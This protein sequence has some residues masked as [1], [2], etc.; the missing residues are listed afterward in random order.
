VGRKEQ[1][2]RSASADEVRSKLETRVVLRSIWSLGKGGRSTRLSTKIKGDHLS[3][4]FNKAMGGLLG[5][6]ISAFKG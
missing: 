6:G 5:I 1:D 4:S 2:R 3:Q